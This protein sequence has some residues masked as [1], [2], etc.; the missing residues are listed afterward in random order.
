MQENLVSENQKGECT[1]NEAIHSWLKKGLISRAQHEILLRVVADTGKS[2]QSTS[3]K[4]ADWINKLFL[5]H[6]RERA[7]LFSE[8]IKT[9]KKLEWN[10]RTLESAR[11]LLRQTRDLAMRSTSLSS[12]FAKGTIRRSKLPEPRN[13]Q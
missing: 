13:K 8:L 6:E 4:E 2:T 7:F 1:P 3:D 11:Q 9:R 10:R 5:N 12:L